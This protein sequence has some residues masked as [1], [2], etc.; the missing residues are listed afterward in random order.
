[1]KRTTVVL[2]TIMLFA[3]PMVGHAGRALASDRQQQP[4]TGVLSDLDPAALY[5]ALAAT[6]M[7]AVEL[8]AGFSS[9]DPEPGT[10]AARESDN[11]AVGSVEM[12]LDK[13][14]RISYTVYPTAGAAA[15]S[16]AAASADFAIF[17]NGLARVRSQTGSFQPDGFASPALC[18]T[19]MSNIEGRRSG[20]TNCF[21]QV[22]NVEVRAFTSLDGART[23]GD[24]ALSI[25]LVNAGIAHLQAVAAG[26]VAAPYAG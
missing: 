12:F 24:D 2:V 25:S 3:L 7:T 6:P 17:S 20:F 10:L 18:I 21:A 9:G 15:Q 14:G 8:P 11:G 22:G 5:A 13:P 1:M 4:S 23:R 16:F 19:S 26:L